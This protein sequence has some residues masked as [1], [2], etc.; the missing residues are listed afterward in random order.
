MA[1]SIQAELWKLQAFLHLMVMSVDF[2]CLW[3]IKMSC[4]GRG[5]EF[6]LAL[7]LHLLVNYPIPF[8][9]SEARD[10]VSKLFR[11]HRYKT[12]NAFQWNSLTVYALPLDSKCL[13]LKSDSRNTP[14]QDFSVRNC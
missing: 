9:K 13:L 10:R 6:S 11:F 4:F 3:S 5:L 8:W 14:H 7:L 1:T 12:D 2:S